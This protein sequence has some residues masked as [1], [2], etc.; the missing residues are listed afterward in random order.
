MR[1]TAQPVEN[2]RATKELRLVHSSSLS[3][4]SCEASGAAKSQ[5]S[6]C[7]ILQN[8]THGATRLELLHAD[9]RTARPTQIA[10]HE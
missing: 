8:N 10:T 9:G 1:W 5:Y 3:G 2:F 4:E 6:V 7:E